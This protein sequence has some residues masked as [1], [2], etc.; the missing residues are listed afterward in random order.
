MATV[1][2]PSFPSFRAFPAV[3]LSSFDLSKINLP[4][5]NLPRVNAADF[6]T[7]AIANA[8]RDGAYIAIGLAVVAIQKTQV[9]GREIVKSVS[10]QVTSAKP[11]LDDVISGIEARFARIDA[12][13][14]SLEGKLDEAV[15]E[16]EKRLPERAGA[17]LVQAHDIAKAAR[18]QVRGLVTTAA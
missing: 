12:R 2:F 15:E 13:I 18:K 1:K 11:Q 5:V 10:A 3:D 17:V 6:D 9:R 8:A 4:K 14:D 7:E 16:F